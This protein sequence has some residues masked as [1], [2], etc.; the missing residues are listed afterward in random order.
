MYGSWYVIDHFIA[1]YE[2]A[3]TEELYKVYITDSLKILTGAEARYFDL[4]NSNS[5]KSTESA[6]SI[7]KR[8]SERLD[9]M[10][11]EQ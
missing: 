3:K 10:G 8:L 7:I 9:E 2:R 6:E 1:E 5:A 11:G 4:V